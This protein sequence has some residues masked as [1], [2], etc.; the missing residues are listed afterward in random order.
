MASLYQ[1]SVGG[2]VLMGAGSRTRWRLALWGLRGAEAAFVGEGEELPEEAADFGVESGLA[3]VGRQLGKC[4]VEVG[5][6]KPVGRSV[7]AAD[8]GVPGVENGSRR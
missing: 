1:G 3:G 7:K 4:S 5:E 8:Q 2:V 6:D